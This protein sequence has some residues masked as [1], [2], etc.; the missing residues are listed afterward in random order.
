MPAA[1]YS[2]A[3]HPTPS[4][5]I[6]RPPDTTSRVA[7]ALAS[8]AGGRRNAG[9]TSTPSR[10]RSVR[11]AIQ[12]SVVNGSG[13]SCHAAPSC[14]IWRRWS[15]NH[16]CST[17]ARSAS[18]TTRPSDSAKLWRPPGQSNVESISPTRI[19]PVAAGSPAATGVAPTGAGR[20]RVVAAERGRHDGN[21][22]RFEHGVPRLG[23]HLVAGRRP[24]PQLRR[25]RGVRHSRVTRCVATPA[26][27]RRGVEHHRHR[28][29]VVGGG[30]LAPPRPHRG[31][32]A[33]GVDGRGQASAHPTGHD[34][35]EHGEGVVRRGEIV[36]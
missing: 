17:P 31:V 7:I 22:F 33:E 10:T 2:A 15:I 20:R 12:A 26:L 5:H 24:A 1:A 11:A 35:V 28:G 19:V 18:P 14:G 29:H 8:S 34:V 32:E 30:Q 25:D 4:P 13:R 3:N 16:T 23:P 6:A 21:R 36:R 27:G 9:V